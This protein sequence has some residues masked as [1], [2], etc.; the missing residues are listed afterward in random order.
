MAHIHDKTVGYDRLVLCAMNEF[1][2]KGK[3]HE[4]KPSSVYSSSSSKI[5]EDCSSDTIPY[6]IGRA[7]FC[8][9]CKP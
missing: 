6:R 1:S 5:K 2:G 3:V 7:F 4:E 9:G 8:F